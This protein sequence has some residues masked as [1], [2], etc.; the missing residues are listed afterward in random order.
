MATNK[1]EK[2]FKLDFIDFE[3]FME[4][5]CYHCHHYHYLHLVKND[6]SEVIIIFSTNSVVQVQNLACQV[7]PLL[8]H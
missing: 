7:S 3:Y 5:Y 2:Y 1:Y 6:H 8:H 4:T